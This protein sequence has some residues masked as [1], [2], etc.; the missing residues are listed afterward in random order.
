MQM[1]EIS[2][3]KTKGFFLCLNNQAKEREAKE[4]QAFLQ[5]REVQALRRLERSPERSPERSLAARS[6]AREKSC[7]AQR[8]SQ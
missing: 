8:I 3:M 2:F 5:A 4:V 7:L 1:Q 6:L